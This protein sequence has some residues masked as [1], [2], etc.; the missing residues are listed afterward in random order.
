M[1]RESYDSFYFANWFD[2]GMWGCWYAFYNDAE[3][4]GES[5]TEINNKVHITSCFLDPQPEKT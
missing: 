5:M 2:Q 3:V 1:K 4:A